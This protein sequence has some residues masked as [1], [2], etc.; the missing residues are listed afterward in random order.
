MI[1]WVLLFAHARRN[2]LRSLLTVGSVAVALFLYC[3]LRT[4]ITSIEATV[5]DASA[6]RLIVQSAVS[7]FM[8]LPI[9]VKPKIEAISIGRAAPVREKQVAR[10]R[11][12]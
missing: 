12:A 4:V 5:K 2:R 6:H 11:A 3:S 1:P 7:L 10:K 8:H 9:S